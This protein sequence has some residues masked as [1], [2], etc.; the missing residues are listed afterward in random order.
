VL[1]MG[2][3]TTDEDMFKVLE[4]TFSERAYTIKIG[5]RGT[6]ARYTISGQQDVL[7]LLARLQQCVK[8]RQ[9]IIPRH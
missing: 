8:P 2:D 7:P 5:N 4:E 1:C 3:D 9:E 6:A